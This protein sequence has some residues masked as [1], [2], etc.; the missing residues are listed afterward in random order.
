MQVAFHLLTLAR[1][2][3]HEGHSPCTLWLSPDMCFHSPCNVHQSLLA[4]TALFAVCSLN[5]YEKINS[6]AANGLLIITEDQQRLW[7]RFSSICLRNGEAQERHEG[8]WARHFSPHTVCVDPHTW[9]HMRVHRSWQLQA[10]S[11]AYLPQTVCS[12]MQ[13]QVCLH[14]C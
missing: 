7:A 5:V 2:V 14:C 6:F 13:S 4:A 1:P 12:L 11:L 3:G 10:S 8:S 9:V